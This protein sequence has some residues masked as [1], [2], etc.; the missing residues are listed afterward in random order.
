MSYACCRYKTARTDACK[1][2]HTGL[3]VQPSSEVEPSGSKH[4]EDLVK[5]KNMN[6]EKV[7]FLFMLYNFNF[8]YNKE[9]FRIVDTSLSY[10]GHFML[11]FRQLRCALVQVFNL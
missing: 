3:Y 9:A 1:T 7:H 5:I 4:V 2:Y 6:L 10:H 8:T 11:A